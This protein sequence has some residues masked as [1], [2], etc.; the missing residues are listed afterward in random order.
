MLSLKLVCYCTSKHYE[1]LADFTE[2][3]EETPHIK[4]L[5]YN[6]FWRPAM[7]HMKRDE[8]MRER[9]M[10]L[11]ERIE[12]YDF[13]CLQEAFQF[14]SSI[15]SDFINEAIKKGFKYVVSCRNPPLCNKQIIDS[16]I[17]LLSKLPIL[18]TDTI[19]YARSCDWDSWS[20]KGVVYAK[21]QIGANKWIHVFTS[22]L[23]SLYNKVE[24]EPVDILMSQFDQLSAFMADKI[25]DCFPVFVSG[26]LN[27]DSSKGTEYEKMLEH[28]NLDGFDRSDVLYDTFGRHPYTFGGLYSPI[29]D[30]SVVRPSIDYIFMF[31][32]HQPSIGVSASG[33]VNK[34]TV[35]GKPFA[36]LSDHFAVEIDLDF[37]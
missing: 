16:G 6:A 24:K 9:A 22:H 21:I 35:E 36:H 17:M 14:G 5:Q 7:I 11:L 33:A 13:I 12:K 1:Y 20:A 18:E 19:R 15:A 4:F 27:V 23:Q 3:I 2:Q 25:H 30:E 32:N 31:K 8:Y 29:T 10:I 26:D 34:M 37:Q 28:L